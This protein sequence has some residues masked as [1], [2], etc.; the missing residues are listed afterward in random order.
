MV[1]VT[2]RKNLQNWCHVFYGRS[3][4]YRGSGADCKLVL[5]IV[6][7]GDSSLVRKVTGSKGRHRSEITVR[8]R[9]RVSTD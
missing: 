9:V 2:E 8:V 1:K 5:A 6:I 7:C 4:K 3:I